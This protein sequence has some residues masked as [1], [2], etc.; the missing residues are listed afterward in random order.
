MSGRPGPVV[1]ALPEDMLSSR[2]EVPDL[3]PPAAAVP[4]GAEAQAAAVAAAIRAAE[5]PLV[6][7]GGSQWSWRRPRRWRAFAEGWGLPVAVSFRR[8]DRLDNAS[9]AYV[10]DLG[11]GMN[12]RLGRRLK[13]ADLLVVLGSRLG[14]IADRR[15]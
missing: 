9:R 13:A 12:P 1:L 3:P 11:V 15:L 7:A 14:D 10:G 5:R 4:G 2:A 6:V 8:Q